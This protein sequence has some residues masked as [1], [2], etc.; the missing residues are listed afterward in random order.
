MNT[1]SIACLALAVPFAL[2]ALLFAV[3]REKGAMLVSG[4]NTL[5]EQER[6]QY[7]KNA[8]CRDMR[9]KL[10]LWTAL[11]SGGALAAHFVHPYCG[12][13]AL[14]LWLALFLKGV[15]TN[16]EAAFAPYRAPDHDEHR[17]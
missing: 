1:A 9:N 17:P 3:L 13:G 16:P 2:F 8:L 6:S 15:R 11:L 7:D 12:W 5:S 10:V 14:A 4:F